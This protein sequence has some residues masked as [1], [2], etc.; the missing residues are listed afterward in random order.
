MKRTPLVTI[1]TLLA[2]GTPAQA[3]SLF[4]DDFNATDGTLLEGYNGYTVTTEPSPATKIAKISGPGLSVTG[5]TSAG[6]S[7]YMYYSMSSGAAMDY[8]ATKYLGSGTFGSAGGINTFFVSALFKTDEFP[9]TT[10]AWFKVAIPLDFA[11]GADRFFAI[12]LKNEEYQGTVQDQIFAEGQG[13][14]YGD[15]HLASYTEGD[16]VQVVAKFSI[17]PMSGLDG[18]YRFEVRAAANPSLTSNPKTWQLI[19]EESN[20]VGSFEV[21]SLDL[22][23]TRSGSNAA[24]GGLIDEIRIGTNYADVVGVVP[25]PETWAM[26]LAGLGLLAGWRLNRPES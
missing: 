15:H 19:T 13:S 22:V 18:Q 8:T 16:T 1:V 9:E 20:K 6:N 2:I 24:A 4:Y 7:A 11:S 10:G 21:P 5:Q 14:Q 3:A 12:G 23:L 17:A 25:E 26:L